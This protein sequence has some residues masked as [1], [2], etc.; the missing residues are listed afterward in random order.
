MIDIKRLSHLQAVATH[1]TV[2]SAANSLHIT[3]SALTKSISRFEEELGA[4]LFD[5]QG[6]RLALTEL[7]RHLVKRGEALI[8]QVVQLEEE[9]ELWKG[10]GTGEVIIGADPE[11]EFGLL[12]GVLESFVPN[13]P[14]VLVSLHSGHTETLL[15]ALL[16]GELHFIIADSEIALGNE[17]LEIRVLASDPLAVALR[18]DHPLANTDLPTPAEVARYPSIGASTAPRF[19][20]WRT[21]RVRR[22][23]EE[24]HTP[25]LVS[26]NYEILVRLAERSDAIVF[27]PRN[28]LNRYAQEGRLAVVKWPL[29]GPNT[30]SSLIHLKERHLSPAAT[31]LI[32]LVIQSAATQFS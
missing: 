16:R 17:N 19:E 9:I 27:G 12:P 6:H 20:R 3:Q 29:E 30:Q 18:P 13:Y 26:D 22:E 32:E 4:P 10:L 11:A 21:E 15:P 25:S 2:Q 1:S 14:G 8:Q 28:L 5:R 7:G 31:R 24:P 23:G